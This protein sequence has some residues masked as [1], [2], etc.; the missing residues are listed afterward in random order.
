MKKMTKF[1][2]TLMIGLLMLTACGPKLPEDVVASVNGVNITKEYYDKTVAK[3]AEDNGFEKI[4]GEDIWSYEVEPGITFRERFA[5]QILDLIIMQEI[6]YQDA[7]SK[8]LRAT[9]EEVQSE[10]DAYMDIVNKDPEY[11]EFLKKN[12]IDETFI[13]EH[14]TRALTHNRYAED[15]Q[16]KIEITKEQAKEYYDSNPDKFTNNKV[17]ASHILF[18]LKEGK[19]PL[20]DQEKAEKLKKAEEILAKARSGEDFAKLAE[21]NSEDPGSAISGGD[22]GFFSPGAM[23]KEFNDKAF[24]ME[25]GEISDI[26]ETEFGYHIIYLTD[27]D[28]SM[29]P[30]DTIK[31]EL[32]SQLKQDQYKEKMEE[33][34]KASKIIINKALEIK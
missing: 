2:A 33:L 27:K 1:V 24:S 26:I 17:R 3:V 13:K 11:S 12:N 19:E 4:Y 22:L 28:Q 20:S 7:G 14:L 10:N 9:E 31:D 8:N 30:F 23:V 34:K 6:V 5:S 29:I 16:S 18:S 32:I 15:I 25:V 21:E